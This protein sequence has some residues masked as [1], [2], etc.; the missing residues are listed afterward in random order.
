MII[1]IIVVEYIKP[2][3]LA[4]V[5]ENQYG[6][7]PRSNV[8][9]ALICMLHTWLSETNGNCATVRAVLVDFRKAFDLSDYKI[10]IQKLTTF[11]PQQYCCLGEGLPDWYRQ[12]VKLSQD[13]HSEWEEIPSRVPQ[14]TKLGTWL[15]TIMINDLSIGYLHDITCTIYL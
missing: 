2:A 6:T 13:C 9:V 10:L 11:G 5:D 15:F 1:I 14:G 4:K 3:I 12:S 7:I 8:T